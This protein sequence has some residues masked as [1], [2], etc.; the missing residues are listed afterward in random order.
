MMQSTNLRQSFARQNLASDCVAEVFFERGVL[1]AACHD[2]SNE[3]LAA[4]FLALAPSTW[5]WL[6]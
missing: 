4:E 2:V 1:G 3:A 6:C 5:C